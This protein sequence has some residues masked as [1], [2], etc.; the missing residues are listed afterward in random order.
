MCSIGIN[1]SELSIGHTALGPRQDSRQKMGCSRYGATLGS[2]D[3]KSPREDKPLDISG[4]PTFT[5][6]QVIVQG[7]STSRELHFF[8]FKIWLIMRTQ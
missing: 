7:T 2:R 5:Q 1:S 4:L 8:A 6:L 3:M